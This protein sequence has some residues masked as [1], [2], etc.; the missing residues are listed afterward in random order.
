MLVLELR[1]SCPKNLESW[2]YDRHHSHGA[3]H[4][5][6]AIPTTF[7]NHCASASA[8]FLEPQHLQ[9]P[10]DPSSSTTAVKVRP[11]RPFWGRSSLAQLVNILM[12]RY[13]LG[14]T[15]VTTAI[16]IIIIIRAVIITTTTVAVNIA[17]ADLGYQKYWQ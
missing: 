5:N 2:H 12:C 15:L 14:M 7:S 11:W 16:I 6:A 10:S 4:T 13:D 8:R 9:A 1:C 17:A 3:K